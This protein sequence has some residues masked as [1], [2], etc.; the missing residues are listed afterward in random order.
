MR[1]PADQYCRLPEQMLCGRLLTLEGEGRAVDD[2]S[3]KKS[4]AI[5]L[6]NDV[7]SHALV[8]P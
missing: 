5:A 6:T 1:G 3:D 2:V 7:A 4:L 8:L